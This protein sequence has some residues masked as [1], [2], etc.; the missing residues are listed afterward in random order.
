MSISHID[1]FV[2]PTECIRDMQFLSVSLYTKKFFK[3]VQQQ[4]YPTVPLFT[5]ELGSLLLLAPV[6]CIAT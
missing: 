3:G 5:L 1:V 2:I 6:I 4:Q